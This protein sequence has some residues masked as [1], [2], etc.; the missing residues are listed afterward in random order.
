MKAETSSLTSQNVV[1]PCVKSTTQQMRAA[2][3]VFS[4]RCHRL[5]LRGHQSHA[6]L[7]SLAGDCWL[8][9][10]VCVC[11]CVCVW[12]LSS[13]LTI[14]CA[15]WHRVT[16]PLSGRFPLR[17]R[18]ERFRSCWGNADALWRISETRQRYVQTVGEV[19]DLQEA[20]VAHGGSFWSLQK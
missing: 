7:P 8:T 20:M 16:A 19:C 17:S 13:C 1:D 15:G 10:C 4:R 18:W 3:L 6:S 11:V 9:V 14:G 5:L 12:R 2:D